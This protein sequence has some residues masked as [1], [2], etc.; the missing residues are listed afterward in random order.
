MFY[1]LMHFLCFKMFSFNG[2]RQCHMLAGYTVQCLNAFCFSVII[3]ILSKIND[4]MR[5]MC[6]S[7]FYR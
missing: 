1:V 6:R 2:S 3:D 5:A 7:L 4:N